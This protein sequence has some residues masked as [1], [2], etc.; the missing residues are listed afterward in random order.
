MTLPLLLL[1]ACTGEDS[2]AGPRL[3]G[4]LSAQDYAILDAGTTWIYR[5]DGEDGVPDEE[6][7]LRAQAISAGVVGLRRGQRRADATEVGTL[8][9]GVADDG[10]LSLQAWALPDGTQGAA[11]SGA[12]L[13]LLSAEVEDGTQVSSEDGGWTCTITA[14]AEGVETYY[15]SFGDVLLADCTG[16]GGLPGRYAF[17]RDIG[18]IA[19][20]VADGGYALELVAPW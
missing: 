16:A 12:G 8:T 20:E 17:A 6:T 3:D 11:S 5:D 1:L 10:A 14:T 7:L 19:L 18:L 15:G 2:A 4:I 13:P 9:W